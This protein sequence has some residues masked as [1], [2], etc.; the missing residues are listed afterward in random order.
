MEGEG[1]GDS[2]NNLRTSGGKQTQIKVSALLI[3]H[4]GVEKLQM[5]ASVET[6]EIK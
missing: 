3:K 4:Q 5:L 1:V 6:D 2:K